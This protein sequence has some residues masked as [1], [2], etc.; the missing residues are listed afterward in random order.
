MTDS[1]YNRRQVNDE[2]RLR[3]CVQ[4]SHVVSSH[5]VV[6]RAAR[7][8]YFRIGETAKSFND[9]LPKKSGATGD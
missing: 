1:P 5:E 9:E 6:V 7:N 3:I 2:V 4:T 8:K